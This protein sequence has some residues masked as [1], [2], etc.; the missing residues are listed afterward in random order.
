ML[1]LGTGARQMATLEA[2]VH[3]MVQAVP[4]SAVR[5]WGSVAATRRF[6]VAE[7]PLLPVV[8]KPENARLAKLAESA[9]TSFFRPADG[10]RTQQAWVVSVTGACRHLCVGCRRATSLNI[11][12]FLTERTAAMARRNWLSSLNTCRHKRYWTYC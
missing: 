9:P 5:T 10:E 8:P 4:R 12:P 11:E 3:G 2:I 1:R 7:P 6:M